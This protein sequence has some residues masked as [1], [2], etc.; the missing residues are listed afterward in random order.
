MLQ[1]HRNHHN[2]NT[3]KPFS[4]EKLFQGRLPCL[5]PHTQGKRKKLSSRDGEEEKRRKRGKEN[6]QRLFT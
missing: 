2:T 1:D 5:C 6:A 3:G 4:V